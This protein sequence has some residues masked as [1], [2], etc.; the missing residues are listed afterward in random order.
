MFFLLLTGRYP[1]TEEFAALKVNWQ[2]RGSLSKS[3]IAFITSLPR[4][5]HPMTMLSMAIL[6]L[7]THSK[8]FKAY[9]AGT[10]KAKY[11]E[12]YFEDTMDLLAKLPLICATIYRHKYH[13]SNLIAPDHS[14]DW[15]GNFGHMLGFQEEQ[16][17]ECLRGYISI[18]ADHE[19]GNVSAHTSQLVGS[20]LA[21]PYLAFSAA[22]NGLAGP[23]HGLANQEC[24]K[25]LTE[26]K[27]FHKGEK[28]N[29]AL[30]EEFVRK[31]LGEGKVIPGYGHAVLRNTD[32]RF[33]HLK[34]FADKNIKDD[35]ICDLARQCFET[36]PGI[37]GTI[38]KIKNPWPNVDAFSGALLQHYGMVE[39]DFYTVVFGVSRALG[40]LSNGI[41]ARIFGLP[42]ERPNSIDIAFLERLSQPKKE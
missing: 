13:N 19:G 3:D 27:D 15:A 40:C 11:W 9:Q 23:L 34:S 5:F 33:L 10:N 24:L 8:F 25:W 29:K 35:Y 26:L 28:P 31:T 38:G 2:H 17:K 20:A 42:I 7:Q 12:H 6:N 37:L 22:M 30:I 41:W 21:D 36:V 18:H 1:T 14:L 16:M 32:P 4:E 39:N